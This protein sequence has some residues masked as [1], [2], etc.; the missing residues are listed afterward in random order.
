MFLPLCPRGPGIRPLS[1][2]LPYAQQGT[3]FLQEGPR[4]P[5]SQGLP[6]PSLPS[7]LAFWPMQDHQSTLARFESAWGAFDPR[8]KKGI[9]YQRLFVPGFSVLKR[10]S[11]FSLQLKELQNRKSEGGG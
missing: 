4:N 5:Q 2:L 6:V 8:Q 10:Q 3:C 7:Q 1:T 9:Y 11:E